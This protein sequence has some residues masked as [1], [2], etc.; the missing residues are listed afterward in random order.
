M[1]FPPVSPARVFA[2]LVPPG[3]TGAEWREK[4]PPGAAAAG[5]GGGGGIP[6]PGFPPGREVHVSGTAE[7]SAAPDRATVTVRL[8]SSKGEAAAA[9]SSVARRLDYVLQA[10]RQR[11]ELSEK[12]LSVTRN[13]SRID[14]AYKMEAEVCITFSDFGKMQDVCNL[15]VEKL[16][17]SVTIDPPHF[18]HTMEAIDVLRRQVCLAAVGSAQQKAKEVCQLFGQSLGKPL[19][20]REEEAKE[21]EGHI[22]N[23]EATSS[24]LL[25]LQ[26][27]RQSATIYAFSRIFAIFEIKGE[28]KRKKAALLNMN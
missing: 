13:F 4:E 11:G 7:L 1:P 18:Y 20:I 26:Q 2:E 8:R 16:D 5:G 3:P 6:A 10:A 24:D 27:R 12:N 23:H 25:S 15:L 19:L 22:G 28:R 9:R 21:W 17:S 14:N